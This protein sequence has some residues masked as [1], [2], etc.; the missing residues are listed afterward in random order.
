M[1]ERFS[2]RERAA[3]RNLAAEAHDHELQNALTDLYDE[4]CVWGGDGMSAFDLNDKIHE[5][6]D[7]ISRE[8]YKTYVLS[9]PE[10]AVT[11]GIFRKTINLDDID[12]NLRE[13]LKPMVEGFERMGEAEKK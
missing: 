7:G 5:F 3:L 9:D 1:S 2:K 11:I 12:K 10:L 8:L 4:F 13:K 6:H